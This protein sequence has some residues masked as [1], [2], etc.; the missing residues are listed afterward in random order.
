M[1]TQFYSLH[2]HAIRCCF[3]ASLLLLF[4]CRDDTP[5]VTPQ[6]PDTEEE[7]TAELSDAYHD[8]IRTAPYPKANNELYLNP[9]PLIVPQS[10]K[11]GE[12]LLFELSPSENF[13]S[14]ETMRSEAE[15][16][17]LFNPHR[18]LETGTWY[19]RFRQADAQGIP[20]GEWSDTYRFEVTEETPAFVTPAFNAFSSSLPARHPRLYCYL[21]PQLEEARRQAS[22]HSEYPTLLSRAQNALNAD[23]TMIN[24]NEDAGRL[25]GHLQMLYDALHLTQDTRYSNRM[26]QLLQQMM[27]YPISDRLLF[28]SN[29]GA[30]DI[31]ICY[32]RIYDMLY[33]ELT[34]DERAVAENVMMR[35]LRKNY[36]MHRG[37]QENHIFDNHFWQQ[38]MRITFQCAFL[39]Y[40]KPAYSAEVLPMLKYYYELWTARAP[41]S[42]F[43]R[44]GVWHNGS[45]YFNSNLETLHYMPMLFTYVTGTDF[46]QHPWYRN[47][48]RSMT[49]T[50]PPRSKSSGFG[51]GS[52]NGD[53]P[54]RQR[55]AFADFLARELNDPYAGWYASECGNA[56]NDYL[57]RLYRMCSTLCY[58]TD[59]PADAAKMVWYED[60][61][62]VAMHSCLTDTDRDVN[63]SFRSSTFGS[64]S[65]TTSSQNA[66]NL[67]FKGKEIYR[68]S[69]YY[70]HFSDAHN[71]MS[72]R[73][74]RAHN[75]ILVNGI[76]QPYSTNGY[77]N[78]MRTLEGEHITYCLGD[79]SKAYY[80]I[81]DDPM[82]V[83]AFEKAGITQTPE[84]GFGETPLTKYRRHVLMLH[85]EGIVL[86][87]DELEASEPVAYDWLLHSPSQLSL[88][89]ELLTINHSSHEFGYTAVTQLFCNNPVN[90][91]L[92][93]RFLVAPDPATMKKGKSYPNQW[94]MTARIEG[95]AKTR[96]LAVIQAN[97]SGIPPQIIRKTGNTLTIGKWTVNAEL[98]ASQPASLSITHADTPVY[99][100]YGKEN[101]VLNGTLYPRENTMSSLLYDA[102][103][104]EYKVT[105][106]NDR[107]PATTRVAR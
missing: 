51:D 71:L 11:T 83:E 102:I 41:A 78:I 91:S 36:S 81:S 59:L 22:K 74:S 2:R 32:A 47:A 77:G 86:I 9:P 6:E 56:Q 29:F 15:E 67:L 73:H 38:N 13:S 26:H 88:N 72:Y 20:Q 65:H 37:M 69:G 21:D 39:L 5:P 100:S 87:Y 104:G 33:N 8:K 49:Y 63:L 94:H 80:G 19:W 48:G 14:T 98:D 3:A 52:E 1:K 90:M 30:T 27:A 75:T 96:I 43:N 66:F 31:A 68:S 10:M 64:G 4:A 45:G 16:W 60:T 34:A 82:W 85:P 55:A 42:G 44:D 28:A 106:M 7:E 101:P 53:E 46:L 58:P 18:K 50:W 25:A 92:T 70:L 79:A 105:E 103:N 57:F 23:Y 17:C 40:N 93:D 99:F 97:A 95:E 89:K 84:N 62:E 107:L 76:G 24:P 35:V 61:G 12:R 54:V